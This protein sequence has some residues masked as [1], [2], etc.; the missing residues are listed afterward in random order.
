MKEFEEAR[1]AYGAVE[2]PPELGE[3]VRRAVRK[4]GRAMRR[5]KVFGRTAASVAACFALLVLTLNLSPAFASYAGNLP[6][7]GG[8]AR[9][10]TARSYHT[11]ENGLTYNVEVPAVAGTDNALTERVNAEIQKRVDEKMIAGQ[12]IADETK[13]AFLETGGTEAE[14]EARGTE[15]SVTYSVKYQSDTTLSFVVDSYVTVASAYQEEDFY[16]LDLDSGKE[17]TLQDLLGDDWVK[18]ANK[19]I[20]KQI[21]E[22]EEKDPGVFFTDDWGFTTVDESTG[23]YLNNDGIPVVVFPRATIAIGAAGP[24]E[25]PI[26]K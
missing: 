4:A 5:A 14:W 26:T 22:R 24:V 12:E 25:F 1:R 16:N 15:V 3:Q 21:G 13:Q 18:V 19:S 23:F 8:L 9:V 17:L 10:L 20:R 6:V 2:I 11:T 7:L